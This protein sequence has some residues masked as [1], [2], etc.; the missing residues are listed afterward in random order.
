MSGARE[1]TRRAGRV[2]LTRTS[3]AG[4][5]ARASARAALRAHRQGFRELRDKRETPQTR[6]VGLVAASAWGGMTPGDD[7]LKRKWTTRI[8][9]ITGKG[10]QNCQ[11]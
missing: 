3:T 1:R 9:N 6:S 7:Y 5:G 11:P 2:G 4:M 10:G 8:V